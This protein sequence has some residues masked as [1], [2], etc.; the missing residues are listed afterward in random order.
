MIHTKNQTGVRIDETNYGTLFSERSLRILATVS[1][2][3]NIEVIRVNTLFL[4]DT[5][6]FWWSTLYCHN[7]LPIRQRNAN[8]KQEFI[9]DFSCEELII[10]FV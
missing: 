9:N 10:G 4:F 8:E 6:E 7:P 5:G 1:S 3:E 2:Q